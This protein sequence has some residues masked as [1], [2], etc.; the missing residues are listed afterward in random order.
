MR[1]PLQ[2]SEARAHNRTRRRVS[3]LE[4]RFHGAR[5]LP[6]VFDGVGSPLS[7][8]VKGDVAIHFEC[9]IVRWR[10]L[11]LEVGDLVVDVWKSDYAGF[12][13]TVADTITGTDKPTLTASQKAESV[14]LTGWE[15]A[16]ADGDVLRFNIDSASAITQATLLLTL[17]V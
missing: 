1:L 16:V 14:A 10:L 11:A 12:P 15:T 2:P 6:V 17:V 5:T 8:G 7:T 13:P 4:K 9:V 3:N